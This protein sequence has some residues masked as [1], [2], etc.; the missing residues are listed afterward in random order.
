MIKKCITCD[1]D[2]FSHRQKNKDCPL[3]LL[4]GKIN[5][6]TFYLYFMDKKMDR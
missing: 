3:D 2:E 1:K 4:V 6:Y 5:Y